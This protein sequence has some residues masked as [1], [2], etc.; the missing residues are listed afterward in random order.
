MLFVSYRVGFLKEDIITI[1][2]SKR[3]VILVVAEA[4]AFVLAELFIG[5]SITTKNA[6]LAGLIEISYPLFIM[7]FSY[8]LFKEN[9]LNVSTAAGGLFIFFGIFIIYYFNK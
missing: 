1:S 8:F 3:L 7:L 6:A 9:Q 4:L 2:T 5:L